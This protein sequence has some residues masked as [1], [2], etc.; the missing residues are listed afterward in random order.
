MLTY[1][2]DGLMVSKEERK[3][4]L[5]KTTPYEDI[6]KLFHSYIY[7]YI[8]EGI[9]CWSSVF[10]AEDGYQ[11]SDLERNVMID[12]MLRYRKSLSSYPPH[13]HIME[14]FDYFENATSIPNGT[15]YAYPFLDEP[16]TTYYV[17]LGLLA[18]YSEYN[19]VIEN[20]TATFISY[21]LTGQK[22]LT[23][24]FIDKNGT[25]IHEKSYKYTKKI[26]NTDYV[27]SYYEDGKLQG[28]VFISKYK[29]DPATL[30]IIE[31]DKMW[32]RSICG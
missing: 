13:K 7:R 2:E 19:V 10:A 18:T 4:L 25:H 15:Y 16:T 24:H 3:M 14:K 12:M 17:K 26:T 6:L 21:F 30:F 29:R 20:N 28:Y 22:K 31:E 8:S 11:D 5:A 23:K 27:Q 9:L 32:L 1:Y